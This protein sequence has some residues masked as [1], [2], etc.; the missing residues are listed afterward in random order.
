MDQVEQVLG[1]VH[2]EAVAVSET[3]T[4]PLAGKW[5]NKFQSIR[6]IRSLCSRCKNFSFCSATQTEFAYCY[7]TESFCESWVD[8]YVQR[9]PNDT[10]ATPKTTTT[11]SPPPTSRPRRPNHISRL[12]PPTDRT[13]ISSND[14]L[15]AARPTNTL[16]VHANGSI[17]ISNYQ[18]G[19]PTVRNRPA[20]RNQHLWNMVR[21][22]G[23]KS[24]R[25]GQWPWQVAIM[26]R[27]REHVCGGTLVSPRWVLTAAHCLRKKL[28]V[29]LGDHNL[30][31]VDGT[32][33]Q[34]RVEA[35]VKHRGFN[36]KTVDN[37]VAMLRYG[38]NI[39]FSK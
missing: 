22:M 1:Q 17:S 15:S 11:T 31:V 34:L 37:D 7:T 5:A 4:R 32:E 6:T 26:N 14:V 8:K 9:V 39:I 20:G 13:A 30:E 25:R 29:N 38:P 10:P 23:G 27:N 2:N 12:D 36:K 33:L 18:C 19:L 24:A 28:F 35:A 21:I 3:N 16:N